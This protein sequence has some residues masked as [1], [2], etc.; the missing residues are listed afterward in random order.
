MSTCSLVEWSCWI[1]KLTYNRDNTDH[2]DSCTYDPTILVW[3]CENICLSSQPH[4]IVEYLI[5]KHHFR[6]WND[7]LHYLQHSIYLQK[8]LVVSHLYMFQNINDLSWIRVLFAM[9]LFVMVLIRKDIDVMIS[10]HINSMLLWIKSFLR[11]NISSMNH[12]H[13]FFRGEIDM[14]NRYGIEF[15]LTILKQN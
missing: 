4:A 1:E 14:N 8:Y 12:P 10:F 11:L 5:F 13:L 15:I 2:Y 7:M 9:F 3:C 6:P